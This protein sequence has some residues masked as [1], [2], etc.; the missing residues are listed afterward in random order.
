MTEKRAVLSK[1]WSAETNN[2]VRLRVFQ[3]M[4]NR[5]RGS[6][7]PLTLTEEL[8]V[9]IIHSL[10][11]PTISEFAEF[12]H[13]SAP[14]ATYKVNSLVRK[15]YIEKVQSETDHRE[16]H[17]HVTDRYRTQYELSDTD[18]RRVRSRLS[19]Q[20]TSQQLETFTQVLTA[21]TDL[22]DEMQA[23]SE[24]KTASVKPAAQTETASA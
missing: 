11:E 12:S 4:L 10:G 20:F 14:N 1:A 18:M 23:E 24:R 3:K 2:R 19:R 7:A 16:Y 6:D 21:I 5:F 13:L 9:E 15:G 8:C 17:L 22:E